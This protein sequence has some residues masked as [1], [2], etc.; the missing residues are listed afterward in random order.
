MEKEVCI[1]QIVDE[2]TENV[3]SYFEIKDGF[4]TNNNTKQPNKTL[5]KIGEF[6]NEF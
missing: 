6:K 5:I 3:C 1:T 4:G 2:I